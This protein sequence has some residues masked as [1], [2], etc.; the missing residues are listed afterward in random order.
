MPVAD[1]QH[2][3]I[4]MTDVLRASTTMAAALTAGAATIWPHG[5]IESARKAKQE[6]PDS[7]L[8]GERGG[9]I[10]D[11]F[12]C[13]NSPREYS[14]S[15]VTNKTM[16]HCTTNG[17]LA[18]ES[19]RGAARVLVGAFVNLT[20]I[21][22]ELTKAEKAIVVCAGTDGEVT[23]E[24]VLFAG[25]IGLELRNRQ[26]EITI[27][28]AAQIAIHHWKATQL[29]T[30]AGTALSEILAECRGGRPLIK[31]GFLADIE[32]CAQLDQF[33]SVPELDQTKWRINI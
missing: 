28:D 30:Q 14:S 5:S 9:Q 26:P 27:S 20:A 13:G 17:T 3:T 19:C 18:L 4:V 8:C 1:R 2:A 25:A 7:L 22:N 10:I 12:D 15:N 21:V 23:S 33:D 29:R 6:T 31:L 24:D 32:F 16:I 11:G